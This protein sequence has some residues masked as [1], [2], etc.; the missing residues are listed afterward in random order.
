MRDPGLGVALSCLAPGFSRP[1]G[2]ASADGTRSGSCGPDEVSY[3]LEVAR[4][5]HREPYAPLADRIPVQAVAGGGH[6]VSTHHVEGDVL[7][8][9]DVF[10]L[11]RTGRRDSGAGSA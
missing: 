2:M 9:G 6:E 8:P 3:R 1:A 11:D 5:R 7:L 4:S 10:Y